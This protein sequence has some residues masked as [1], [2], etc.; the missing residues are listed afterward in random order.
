MN[1][2]AAHD[3]AYDVVTASRR[4]IPASSP[5]GSAIPVDGRAGG[6]VKE[7]PLARVRRF[8]LLISLFSGN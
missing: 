2:R 8:S 5:A 1:A 7:M 6:G 3:P 4:S